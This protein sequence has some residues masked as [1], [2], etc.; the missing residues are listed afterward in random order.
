[1]G[2]NNGNV[3]KGYASSYKFGPRLLPKNFDWLSLGTTPLLESDHL[4]KIKGP[5]VSKRTEQTLQNLLHM[6]TRVVKCNP[7]IHI[8]NVSLGT[9][10][11][12]EKQEHENGKEKTTESKIT[13]KKRI[14]TSNLGPK[15][16]NK[17]DW[18]NGNSINCRQPF[19]DHFQKSKIENW[20]E[21]GA[22]LKTV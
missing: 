14:K 21:K 18:P 2:S 17:F 22:C 1:M 15:V 7:K 5:A 16:K 8:R 6:Y 20:F 4:L 10:G 12:Y 11:K 9:E 3:A 13:E 19:L